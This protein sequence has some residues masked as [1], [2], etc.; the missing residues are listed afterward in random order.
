MEKIEIPSRG[1]SGVSTPRTRNYS[2]SARYRENQG[3][4]VV[5]YSTDHGQFDNLVNR[6]ERK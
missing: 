4:E 2:G 1:N 3:Y 5:R 6:F